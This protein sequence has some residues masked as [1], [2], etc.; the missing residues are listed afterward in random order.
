M[1]T[2]MVKDYV[3]AG[4]K[5]EIIT[6]IEFIRRFLMHVPPKRFVRILIMV[7]CQVVSR[8]KLTLGEI[9]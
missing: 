2:F 4:W 5:E 8:K 9:C 7:Y 3:D 1:V 6:G